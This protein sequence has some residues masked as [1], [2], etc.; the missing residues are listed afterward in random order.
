MYPHCTY[1]RPPDQGAVAGT[2]GTRRWREPPPGRMVIIFL[3]L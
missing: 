3:A 1:P 2:K